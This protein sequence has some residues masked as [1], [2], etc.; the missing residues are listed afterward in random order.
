[1]MRFRNIFLVGGTALVLGALFATDPDRGV[2]TGMLLLSLVTPILAVA[3]AHLARKALHDYPEADARDLFK[4]AR[5]GNVGAG[6]ALVAMAI[7]VYG[8]LGLFGSVA[9][10]EDAITN[11]RQNLPILKAEQA[12]WWPDHPRPTVLGGMVE[13]ETCIT[14]THRRCWSQFAQL[15]SA[16]EEGAGLGQLTRAFNADGS[17]RFDALAELR[18][19]HAALRELT[20]ANVYQRADQQ[21]RALVLKSLDD[22]RTFSQI[23]APDHRLV[24]QVAAYNRGVGGIQ[25]ERRACQV[26]DGCDPQQWWGHVETTCT[27]SRVPLYGGR[28]ACD[29]NRQHVVKVIKERAPRYAGYL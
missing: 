9:K 26:T 1:M 17:T 3:F 19:R 25:N 20:W 8:L 12:R 6:L 14:L 21:L 13:Q 28:S 18:G 10:A 29:I 4:R 11:V 2:S 16:R 24:F 23:Q 27:A 22:Y 15:K 7:V 5:D